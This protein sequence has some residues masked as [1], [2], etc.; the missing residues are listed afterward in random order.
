MNYY[1][2]LGVDTRATTEQIKAAFRRKALECHPDRNLGGTEADNK[3]FRLISE[4]Y[5]VLRDVTKRR[6]YDRILSGSFSSSSSA[7]GS[8]RETRWHP[9]GQTDEDF[10]EAFA[11]WWAR[12]GFGQHAEEQM[13]QERQAAEIRA[14][15]AAWAAEKADAQANKER[16]E[17]IRRKTEQARQARHA[18]VL[19]KHWQTH[20]GFTR[21]DALLAGI[22][23]VGSLGLA[24][25]WR[26]QP[27]EP[28]TQHISRPD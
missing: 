2:I 21:Q 6:N 8:A 24:Q 16:F 11:R 25:F 19:R 1:D 23:L 20:A 4:A 10:D 28:R 22:L 7:P 18:K 5:E 26:S 27:T 3:Q 15:A 14:R 9:H 12:Q 13:R 17:R